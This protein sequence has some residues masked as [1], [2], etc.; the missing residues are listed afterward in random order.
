[1]LEERFFSVRENCKYT[2][3]SCKRLMCSRTI[4]MQK[5]AV[6]MCA[7][8]ILEP[9]CMAPWK[10]NL[11]T[12]AICACQIAS[13][14]FGLVLALTSRSGEGPRLQTTTMSG[15]CSTYRWQS[16]VEM[17]LISSEPQ[18]LQP[19]DAREKLWYALLMKA[20]TA[21]QS[22]TSFLTLGAHS[23]RGLR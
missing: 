23:Q 10:K 16:L 15:M 8:V 19:R 20:E 13:S 11:G 5:V 7:S 12:H 6:S 1:M 21:V 22:S 3:S 17:N 9:R 18:V 14:G 2:R 4:D